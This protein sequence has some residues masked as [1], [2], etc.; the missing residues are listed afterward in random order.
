MLASNS[1]QN[2]INER[3]TFPVNKFGIDN[4]VKSAA[5]FGANASGKSNFINSLHI[6]QKGCCEIKNAC[7]KSIT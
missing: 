2:N 4:L 3:N 5:I 1:T 6:L 7:K